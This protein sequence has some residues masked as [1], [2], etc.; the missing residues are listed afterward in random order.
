MGW[1]ESWTAPSPGTRALDAVGRRWSRLGN[2]MLETDSRSKKHK[3]K[4]ALFYALNGTVARTHT[5]TSEL[6]ARLLFLAPSNNSL[7]VNFG[8][9]RVGPE[10]RRLNVL[11]CRTARP[12]GTA[13][14]IFVYVHVSAYVAWTRAAPRV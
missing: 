9:G 12:G 4:Q 6:W 7:P 10:F 2:R 8:E 3:T 11:A 13:A 5:V 14:C 1:A